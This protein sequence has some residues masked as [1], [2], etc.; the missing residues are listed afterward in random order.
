MRGHG[1]NQTRATRI[2]L[3]AKIVISLAVGILTSLQ[4]VFV[5]VLMVVG[6]IQMER[7]IVVHVGNLFR[8]SNNL[9]PKNEGRVIF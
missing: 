2:V 1:R 5:A 4:F 8:F 6:L 3:L 9:L 7:F